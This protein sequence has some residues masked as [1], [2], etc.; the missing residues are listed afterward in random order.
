MLEQRREGI[1]LEHVVGWAEFC[2]CWIA[3]VPDVCVPRRRS[4]FLV[5]QELVVLADT[6]AAAAVHTQAAPAPVPPTPR[7]PEVLALCCGT[8]ALGVAIARALPACELH[9]SD[10]DATAVSCAAGNIAVF[11]GRAHCGN[12]FA[13]LPNHLRGRIHVI[14]ANAP[15]VPTAGHRVPAA[16]GPAAGARRRAQRRSRQ[17]CV[18][19]QNSRSRRVFLS[20]AELASL[21][22]HT[23]ARGRD[24]KSSEGELHEFAQ[25]AQQP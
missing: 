13:A 17:T 23:T 25:P 4:E 6:D 24:P 3:V 18:A 5:Q 2:G 14:V 10:V 12:L 11:G 7:W 21:D 1:P 19:P 9:A 15:Y 20:V 22:V 16:G 8:G